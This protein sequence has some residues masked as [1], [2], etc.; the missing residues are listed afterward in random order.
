[1]SWI[2]SDRL[3]LGPKSRGDAGDEVGL[4]KEALGK[5]LFGRVS[6]QSHERLNQGR[7]LLLDME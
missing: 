6:S 2:R 3:G 1:M 7:G 4:G 5:L